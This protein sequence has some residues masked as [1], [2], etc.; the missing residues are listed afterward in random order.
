M[1][2]VDLG[3]NFFAS[4]KVEDIGR[5]GRPAGRASWAY[6]AGRTG[7]AGQ[8]VRRIGPSSFGRDEVW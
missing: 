8:L 1:A 7:W 4:R 3:T 2:F 6:K 5:A